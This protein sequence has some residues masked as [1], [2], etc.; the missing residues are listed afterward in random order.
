MVA[1]VALCLDRIHHIRH[2][3]LHD[4]SDRRYVSYQLSRRDSSIVRD[5]GLALACLQ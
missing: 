5:L 1:V 4:R 2:L 3:H